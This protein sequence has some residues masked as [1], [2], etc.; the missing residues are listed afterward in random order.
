[1]DLPGVR[2]VIAA[3][4]RRSRRTHQFLVWAILVLVPSG[5]VFAQLD[6]RG[7][8]VG[9]LVATDAESN[10]TPGEEE[11]DQAQGLASLRYLPELL[12]EARIKGRTGLTVLASAN[13]NA[14]ATRTVGDEW[15]TDAEADF[16]RLWARLASPRVEFRVG[17]QKIAFGS[18]TLL[19]PLQ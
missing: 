9:S 7:E 16:Y 12:A 2:V 1:M 10:A 14:T 6:F 3:V 17:L 11:S 15:L 19:R 8:L 18:A 13:L 5:T 4:R